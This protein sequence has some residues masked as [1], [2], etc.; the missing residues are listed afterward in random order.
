M[1]R[2]DSFASRLVRHPEPPRIDELAASRNGHRK[3]RSFIFV[4]EFL[5]DFA[6]SCAF[7]GR[8]LWLLL[9][10]RFGPRLPIKIGK[11]VC[12]SDQPHLPEATTPAN[13]FHR[14]PTRLM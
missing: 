6:N 8:G 2:S 10:F 3:A 11:T 7:G 9:S 13:R 14:R 1:V 5:R 12:S 4:Q